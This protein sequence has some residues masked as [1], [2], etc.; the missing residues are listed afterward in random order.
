[1]FAEVWKE[2][3]SFHD[4]STFDGNMRDLRNGKL[5]PRGSWQGLLGG[6]RDRNG[7]PLLQRSDGE[8][9]EQL[10]SWAEEQMRLQVVKQP[11]LF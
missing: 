7:E 9:P 10:Q 3:R 2:A 5:E 4:G 8:Q 11:I 6:L 1:M